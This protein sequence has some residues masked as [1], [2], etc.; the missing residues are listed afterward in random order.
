MAVKDNLAVR[1][2]GAILVQNSKVNDW[3]STKT[4]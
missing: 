2:L 3:P 1:Q 4:L